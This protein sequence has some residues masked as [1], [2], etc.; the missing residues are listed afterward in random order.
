MRWLQFNTLGTYLMTRRWGEL[1]GEDEFGNRYYRQRGGRG[2][3]GERRWVV[4]PP[5]IEPEAT[6]VP[7]GWHGWLHHNFELPPSE[8]SLPVKRWEKKH[9]PN[10]TGL[11]TAYLP[12]GHELRGGRRD[13]A[14]GDYEPWRP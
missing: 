9:Q 1:V 6:R 12:P 5:G 8:Q 14:T 13:R 7:A 4:Y 3:R 11:P 2:P 10:Q